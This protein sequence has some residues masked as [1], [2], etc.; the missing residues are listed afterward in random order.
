MAITRK[1][2]GFNNPADIDRPG[3]MAAALDTVLQLHGA[4]FVRPTQGEILLAPAGIEPHSLKALVDEWRDLPERRSGT[5]SLDDLASFIALTNRWKDDDSVIYA[6]RSEAAPTFTTVFDEHRAGSS[7]VEEAARWRKH[8]A[9]FAPTPSEPWKAWKEIDGKGMSQT[10]LVAFLEARILDIAEPPSDQ[11]TTAAA[12]IRTLGGRTTGAS[13]MLEIARGLKVRESSE[14]ISVNNSA[15]GEVEVAFRSKLTNDADQ[16]L[17]IPSCFSVI[18]P[19]FEGGENFRLWM[20]IQM[21]KVADSDGIQ[22]L[23]W[24][25]T[26]YRP[27]LIVQAGIEAML[28]DIREQTG[29]TVLMGSPE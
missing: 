22:K 29:L 27:D 14:V 12:L 3:D 8:R 24:T 9:R 25:L 17:S 16:P 10:T 28:A 6:K 15:T 2:S 1:A 4:N 11:D 26:R 5:T 23:T 7:T 21:K 13:G 18:A 20:R 19:L